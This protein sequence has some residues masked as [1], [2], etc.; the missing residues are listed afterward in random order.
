MILSHMQS[1]GRNIIFYYGSKPEKNHLYLQY[2]IFY[3]E[4]EGKDLH[5]YWHHCKLR[6]K[7]EDV[8]SWANI[9]SERPA[10]WPVLIVSEPNWGTF[11]HYPCI[12]EIL[13]DVFPTIW[14]QTSPNHP[15]SEWKTKSGRANGCSTLGE[16]LRCSTLKQ[17]SK[18]RTG[19]HRLGIGLYQLHLT[20]IFFGSVI[21]TYKHPII[22]YT[23][24]QKSQNRYKILQTSI[25]IY[26]K[27]S[28][29]IYN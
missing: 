18:D 11:D 28:I 12:L 6:M 21:N 17:P 8:G 1:T 9:S 25:N 24:L 10:K 15:E 19:I 22:I 13:N 27:D 29:N 4:P 3:N 20:S 5:I 2:S 26:C 16:T 14:V 7:W 23:H